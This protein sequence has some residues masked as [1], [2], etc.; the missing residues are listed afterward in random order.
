MRDYWNN[1]GDLIDRTE[2][3]DQL[4]IVDLRIP[5]HPV[6]YTHQAFDTLINSVAH[7]LTHQDL[8]QGDAI[9]I[10]SLNR[11]EY[12]AV[13]FG[14]MRAGFV[15]V[16]VNIKLPQASIQHILKDADVKL[17]FAE[18]TYISAFP[19]EIPVIE[20]DSDNTI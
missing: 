2:N 5:D 20:F 13:Y 10:A 15:A 18:S 19:S 8:Q 16:P 3:L 14:I 1:M 9:A 4:A 12:L 17:I 6:E 7:Y 11:A